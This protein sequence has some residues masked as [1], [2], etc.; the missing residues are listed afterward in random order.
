MPSS[1][2]SGPDPEFYVIQFSTRPDGRLQADCR[3]GHMLGADR[4]LVGRCVVTL[5]L[6]LVDLLGVR[7]RD[8]YR[9][10][11][12]YLEETLERPRV[13]DQPPPP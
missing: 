7:V 12:H 4:S 8:R 6:R 9:Y 5:D 3:T 1:T 11:A 13:L 10:L 2:G